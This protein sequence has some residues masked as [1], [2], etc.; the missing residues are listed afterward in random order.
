VGY[1]EQLP[2]HAAVEPVNSKQHTDESAADYW[3][4]L[5]CL[6]GPDALE[7]PSKEQLLKP[8]P[9][10]LFHQGNHPQKTSEENLGALDLLDDW[11]GDTFLLDDA[12][13]SGSQ[14]ASSAAATTSASP[15]TSKNLFQLGGSSSRSSHPGKG[16]RP[17][18]LTRSTA[19][20][21]SEIAERVKKRRQERTVYYFE[22]SS[23]SDQS[24][25]D[26]ALSI[27]SSS[28][29]DSECKPSIKRQ[30]RTQVS[31]SSSAAQV[32]NT[33]ARKI[34][35]EETK[36][37]I[38]KAFQ[39]NPSLLGTDLA[40]QFDLH[41]QTVSKILKSPERQAQL[42]A[43]Q[44][45]L[46]QTKNTVWE[47][48][49]ACQNAGR[50]YPKPT[51]LKNKFEITVTTVRNW[52]NEFDPAPLDEPGQHP[53]RKPCIL[54]YLAGKKLTQADAEKKYNAKKRMITQWR[55]EAIRMQ[56]LG[57]IDDKS[58]ASAAGPASTG[59]NLFQ[60]AATQAQNKNKTTQPKRSLGGLDS[61]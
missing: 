22:S 35:S 18:A 13:G 53:G 37:A 54:D 56:E 24:E 5:Q 46:E 2:T 36:E 57:R 52:R 45:K 17:P 38:K 50:P 11:P 43:Q 16:K 8:I 3:R 23:E 59:G 12:S 61:L 34:T 7:Q 60:H 6:W 41:Q 15:S 51:A 21:G 28:S 29:S 20:D 33:Q 32:E 55:S 14:P 39:A 19:P 26:D 47:I 25:A 1:V 42:E 10:D 27:R 49:K 48:F 31:S 40:K 30:Q 44:T 9:Q 4:D 58:A